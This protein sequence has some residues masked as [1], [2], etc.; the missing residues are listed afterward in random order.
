MRR[1]DFIALVGSAASWPLAA[2]AQQPALPV[3]AFI[4]GGSPVADAANVIAFRKGLGEAGF[5]EN[6]NVT[7]DYH[8]LEGRYDRLPT[9]MA[10]LISR[11]VTVIAAASVPAALAAKAA[12]KTIPIIFGVAEDPVHLGL[13]DSLARPG[14][15]ATGINWFVQEVAAKRLRLLHDLVP[16]AV[17]V[18]VLVNPGNA[19]SAASTAREVQEAAPAMGL[20]IKVVNAATIAEIDGAFSGFARERPDALFVAPDAF[21]TSR[22][23]Q[24][25]TLTARDGIPASY[26]NRDIVV[27]GGLMSYGTDV[28]DMMH[29]VGAYT[30]SVLKGAKPAE[31]PVL[32][33]TKFVFA[34][35]AG[36]ARALGIEVPPALLSIADEVIE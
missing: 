28:E 9:M 25:V 16:K 18:A 6:Q 32:Q 15:N 30:A 4:D 35:N 13:V 3:V 1:R 26:G 27:A 19:A 11:P 23:S 5:I 14:G 17:R 33:S 12:T 21:L 7:I 10:D 34:I 24:F 36:T 2:R 29:Q 31:L 8:W 20:Q 22:R